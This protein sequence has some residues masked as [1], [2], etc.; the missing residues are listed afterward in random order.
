[1]RRGRRWLAAVVAGVTLAPAA[2]SAATTDAHWY[3]I[4]GE[5]GAVLGWASESRMAIGEGVEVAAQQDIVLAEPGHLPGHLTARSVRREDRAGHTVLLDSLST[6]DGSWTRNTARIQGPKAVIVHATAFDRRTVVVALPADVR[7]DGGEDMLGAWLASGAPRLELKDFDADDMAVERVVYEI[8]PPRPDD[9]P[10]LRAVRR[11]RYDG[12]SLVAVSRLLLD[13]GGQVT[14]AVQPMLGGRFTVSAVDQAT[15]QAPHPPYRLLASVM[16]KSPYHIP[17]AAAVGHMRYRFGFEDG[18]AFAPPQTGEQRVVADD[19]GMVLDICKGCGPGLATDS[20]TLADA[21]RPTAWLQS[22]DPRIRA[23]AAPVAKLKLSDTRKMEI[24]TRIT[25][26]R[27]S[28][29]DFNGHFSALEALQRRRG[30]CTETAVL[31]AALGRAAGIPTR[32]AN[33]LI[34]SSE[35]YHGV[36]NA[37]MPHSWTLAFVDGHW[38]SFD[39]AVDAGFD[40]THIALNAGDGDARS[41]N[42]GAQLASLLVWKSMAEVKRRDAGGPAV[43]APPVRTPSE[44]SPGR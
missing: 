7:F 24:L 19:D 33:G 42:A 8:A 40:S 38:M 30:D 13:Q 18:L 36:S 35:Q 26:A 22:D 29:V 1:M 11:E 12:E 41:V 21:L 10:N 6:V 16:R 44:P 14:R 5:D 28:T 3:R 17:D 27:I 23:I 25:N 32:V 31:L 15:A 9:P 39:A 20:A 2:A 43:P 4:A 34:Y 37:F